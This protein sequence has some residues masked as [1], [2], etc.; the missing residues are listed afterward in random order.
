[1][2]FIS[3]LGKPNKELT[4]RNTV[5]FHSKLYFMSGLLRPLTFNRQA[6]PSPVLG[7][8]AVLTRCAKP[9]RLDS[10][11]HQNFSYEL[12]L[13]QPHKRQ[14]SSTNM[15]CKGLQLKAARSVHLAGS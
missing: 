14:L 10:R 15:E 13:M 6:A 4:V 5:E 8:V 11:F 1:M 3:I 2:L 7:H 9:L 12:Q